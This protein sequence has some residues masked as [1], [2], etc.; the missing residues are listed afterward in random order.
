MR[1]AFFFLLTHSLKNRV[2]TRVKRLR[3]PKYLFSALAGLAYLYFAFLHPSLV[4]RSRMPRTALTPDPDMQ[5][6]AELL[7]ACILGAAVILQFYFAN[8]RT[9]L[10]NG[11]EVQFLFPAPVSHGA[12]LNYRLAKAQTGIIFGSL[13][14]LLLFGRSRMFSNAIFLL[15]TIW[16]VY[17]FLFL[18]RM[19]VLMGKEND[20]QQGHASPCIRRWVGAGIVLTAVFLVASARWFYPSPPM[21]SQLT[22]ENFS[23]WLKAITASGPVYYALFPF[24]LFVR[25]AFAVNPSN[26]LL[27]FAPVFVAS[28]ALYATI[29]RS[30]A[31]FET[32]ILGQS[33]ME[34]IAGPLS[35]STVRGRK[36]GKPRRPPFHLDPDGFAPIGIYWKN[37]SLVVGLSMRRAFSGIA[38]IT[39][40]SILLAGAAGEQAPLVIGSACAAMAGFLALMGPI[41]FRDDLRTDLQNIDLLKTYPIPGWGI[42]LG[43][44]LGPATVLAVLQLGL[45]LLAAGILPS[46]EDHPWTASQRIYVGIGVALLLPCLSF[47]GILVQNAAVLLLPGWIY[48][49]M[50]YP[51]GVEAMG[52]R[53][54]SSLATILCLL[55][56]AVPAALLFL[57]AGFAGYRF[58]GLAI[59][60]VAAF[61]ACVGL[62]AE[63]AFGI[64]HL[65]RLFDKF[66]P[67]D[68]IPNS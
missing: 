44:V 32:S 60:P 25:P 50:E 68:S 20:E 4:Y 39:I 40:L 13:I 30:K 52:Q 5:G 34:E 37:L 15:I 22:V 29:R 38:A 12:L 36:L 49:G 10:F 28:A 7:F 51:R 26:F 54:I 6:L 19:A 47:I 46:M 33:G 62:L 53:L 66:D 31:C 14:S 55:I 3:N 61:V 42:V 17:S 8:A 43:E 41:L 67:S 21:G 18:Y 48:L 1:F 11:A 35:G 64:F 57:V 58:I 59:V 16:G 65:G 9:P 63:G 45:V 27:G 24:R 23:G 56:A 2:S